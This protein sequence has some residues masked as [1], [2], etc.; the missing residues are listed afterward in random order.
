MDDLTSD[1]TP[2]VA[3]TPSRADKVRKIIAVALMALSLAL[4]GVMAT[5]VWRLDSA[6]AKTPAERK[7]QVEH[8]A[9]MKKDAL[10]FMAIPF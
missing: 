1:T 8:N 2:D 5:G 6:K 4:V 10:I 7:W 3:P 9:R